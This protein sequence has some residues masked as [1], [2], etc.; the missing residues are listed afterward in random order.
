MRQQESLSVGS[1]AKCGHYEVLRVLRRNE[2]ICA[3]CNAPRK[4]AIEA[5]ND[6][7]EWGNYLK[8]RGRDDS[9]GV[10][11]ILRKHCDPEIRVKPDPVHKPAH[12]RRN[13]IDLWDTLEAWQLHKDAYLYQAAQYIFRARHKGDHREDLE[14]AKVYIDRALVVLERE[15]RITEQERGEA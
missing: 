5:M 11:E 7:A 2:G 12:Y 8:A 4:D 15:R 6:P 13:G 10:A 9:E 1:C 14:K 3:R